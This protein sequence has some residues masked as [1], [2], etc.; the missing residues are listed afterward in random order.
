M[1]RRGFLGGIEYLCM[2]SKFAAVFVAMRRTGWRMSLKLAYQAS[3]LYI[4]VA[5]VS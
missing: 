2:T 4:V 3:G 1:Q 5:Q